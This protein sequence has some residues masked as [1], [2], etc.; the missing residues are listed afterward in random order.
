MV[1][2][3]NWDTSE[4]S[5]EAV[6]L[7]EATSERVWSLSMTV[8]CTAGNFSDGWRWQNFVV[9]PVIGLGGVGKHYHA[10]RYNQHRQLKSQDFV[11]VNLLI[12]GMLS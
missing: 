7:E 9:G 1:I 8:G 11:V 4:N 2:T 12:I 10:G 3:P 6:R 5:A